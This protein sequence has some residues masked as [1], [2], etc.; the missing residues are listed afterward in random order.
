MSYRIA[1]IDVHKKKLAVV[2]VD[3]EVDDEYQFERRWFNSLDHARSG[4]DNLTAS[5]YPLLKSTSQRRAIAILHLTDFHDVSRAGG[6][7]GQFTRRGW[8][9]KSL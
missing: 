2:V 3:V 9:S 8:R 6:P 7:K 4:S 5:T 1:G